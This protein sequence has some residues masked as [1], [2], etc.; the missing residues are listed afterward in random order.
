MSD[1]NSNDREFELEDLEEQK[2]HWIIEKNINRPASAKIILDSKELN[3]AQEKMYGTHT[4]GFDI[5]HGDKKEINNQTQKSQ[6]SYLFNFNPGDE[7]DS[8]KES[9][10]RSDNYEI[11]IDNN[12][13][14]KIN[15]LHS[16]YPLNKPNLRYNEEGI[17]I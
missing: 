8:E 9:N 10:R 17:H 14:W 3:K 16:E 4:Q 5:V 11:L 7:S 6:E 1:I 15:N 2:V 13:F 12:Q